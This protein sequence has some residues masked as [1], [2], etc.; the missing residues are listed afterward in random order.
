MPDMVICWRMHLGGE[1]ERVV[2][3]LAAAAAAFFAPK[4]AGSAAVCPEN[5]WILD[6]VEAADSV[7]FNVHKW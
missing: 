4:Y 2:V 5:R 1:I 6:G 7:M 3:V